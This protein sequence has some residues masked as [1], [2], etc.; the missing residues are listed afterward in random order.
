MLLL[1]VS[2]TLP[3]AVSTVPVKPLM[4]PIA[5]CNCASVATSEPV[6]PN[7]MVVG[8][9]LTEMVI[10]SPGRHGA[11]RQQIGRLERIGPRAKADGG[12]GGCRA[13]D[14]DRRYAVGAG[15]HEVAGAAAAERGGNVQGAA[16]VS[17]N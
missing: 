9:P 15:E 10:V 16:G 11:L 14:G 4:P 1:E 6:V 12:I 5:D 3:L 2:E 13:A 8:V 17:P 7:V